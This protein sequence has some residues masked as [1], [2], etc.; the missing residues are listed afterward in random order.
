MKAVKQLRKIYDQAKGDNSYYDFE[1]FVKDCRDYLKQ[2][3]KR[4]VIC[5]M[6]VSRSGMMRHFNTLHHNMVLNICYNQKFSW[7]SVRVGGCGMDMHWHLLY[8]AAEEI[9]TRKECDK[10][11]FNGLASEQPII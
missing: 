5:S 6:T 9:A 8:R 10:Y 7:D 11:R 3:K 1:Y 2:L 4:N